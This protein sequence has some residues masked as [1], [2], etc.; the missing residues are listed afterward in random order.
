MLTSDFHAFRCLFYPP[1]QHQKKS[2]FDILV[3][4][5]LWCY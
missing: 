4:V 1:D 5:Y 2:L 3:S